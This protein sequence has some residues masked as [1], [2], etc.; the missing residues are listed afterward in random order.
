MTAWMTA[1]EVAAESG[2]NHDSVL[3]ALRV[4]LLKGSQGGPGCR[5][6]I[7]TSNFNRWAEAGFP[8]PRRDRV[9]S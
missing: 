3:D 9:A 7:S 1:R 4:G 5:W 2:R 8:L 6:V